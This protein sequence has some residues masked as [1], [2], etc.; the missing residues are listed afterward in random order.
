MW[1][2]RRDLREAE[3][4]FGLREDSSADWNLL[5]TRF[6]EGLRELKDGLEA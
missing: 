3:Q 4:Y 1:R 5:R 2:R 6:L